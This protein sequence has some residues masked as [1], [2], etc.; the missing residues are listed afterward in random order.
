MLE[1]ELVSIPSTKSN[2]K[3]EINKILPWIY[4]KKKD[5]TK[6][7]IDHLVGHSTHY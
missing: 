4:S 2:M 6:L 3:R 1:Q 7:L 5:I